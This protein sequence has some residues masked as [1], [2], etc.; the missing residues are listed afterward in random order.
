MGPGE[1]AIREEEG[2]WYHGGYTRYGSPIWGK[3]VLTNKRFTFLEQ[4][5]VKTGLLKKTK[6]LETVGVRINI[7][8]SKLI[9]AITESRVRKKGT[10]NAPPSLF[11]KESYTVLIV[12]LESEEGVVENPI[13]EVKNPSEWATAIQRASGG[14]K[15]T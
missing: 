8:I 13:F 1:K 3:L 9:G 15:L 14:E 11:S 10:L 4:K 6:H 7:P 2:V 12:S 5:V